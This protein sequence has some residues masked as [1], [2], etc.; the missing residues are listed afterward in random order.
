MNPTESALG[1]RL[2]AAIS[3]RQH[4]FIHRVEVLDETPSTQDAARLLA[5]GE[6][7]LAVFALRQTSGRG[8]LGRIW[9]QYLDLGLAATFVLDGLS[10]SRAHLS[11]GCGLAAAATI[12]ALIPAHVAPRIGLRWPNDVVERPSGRK[13]AGVLIESAD[14]L[15]F[16][17]IGINVLH[18]AA[19]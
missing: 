14:S 6:P 11:L 4:R 17:G 8:R 18:T 15:A 19:D 16:A 1:P 13:L 2:A 5:A 12:E 9:T 3:Q 7:G 10:F